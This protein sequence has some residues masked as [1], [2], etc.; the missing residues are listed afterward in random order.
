[1]CAVRLGRKKTPAGGKVQTRLHKHHTPTHHT[2]MWCRRQSLK[3]ESA[4]T[5]AWELALPWPFPP[6]Q[7]HKCS[8]ETAFLI[9]HSKRELSGYFQFSSESAMVSYWARS[10]HQLYLAPFALVSIQADICFSIFPSRPSAA[11]CLPP[12]RVT[13][14]QRQCTCIIVVLHSE[15]Y[16]QFGQH[17]WLFAKAWLPWQHHP[18]IIIFNNN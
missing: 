14:G 18:S 16:V 2:R 7:L 13:I 11:R 17:S 15:F 10:R 9:V 5:V 6:G 8:A 12:P 4:Q 3:V 1:M